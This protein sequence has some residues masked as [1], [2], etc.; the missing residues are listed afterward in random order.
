MALLSG[1]F[2][3]FILLNSQNDRNDDRFFGG[4]LEEKSAD[5]VGNI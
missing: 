4:F 1:F 2:N 3:F 5:I